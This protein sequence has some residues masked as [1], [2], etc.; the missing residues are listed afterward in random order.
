MFNGLTNPTLERA[1]KPLICALYVDYK[2]DIYNTLTKVW[3]ILLSVLLVRNLHSF[4]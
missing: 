2:L 3:N 4:V 1:R